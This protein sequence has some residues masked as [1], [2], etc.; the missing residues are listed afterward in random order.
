MFFCNHM[1]DCVFHFFH[2][3][4]N[5]F[6]NLI[7]QAAERLQG[8]QQAWCMDEL[9]PVFQYVVI[10]ARVRHLGAEIAYIEQLMEPHLEYGELGIMFTT[11]K[12]QQ[13][14]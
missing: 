13:T 9:F 7:L 8:G 1:F 5:K 11:L 14:L 6:L 2:L 4:I 3:N 12:V 10:R